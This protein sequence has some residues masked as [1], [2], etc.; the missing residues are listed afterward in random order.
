MAGLRFDLTGQ[1]LDARARAAAQLQ[2]RL[3]LFGQLL[4]SPARVLFGKF[5]L[6]PQ[7]H[8]L[9]LMRVLG[10]FNVTQLALQLANLGVES[11]GLFRVV[12]VLVA[13]ATDLILLLCV[14]RQQLATL[15]GQYARRRLLLRELLPG[16]DRDALHPAKLAFELSAALPQ[17]V[18][19]RAKSV[20]LRR[21]ALHLL[22]K[23]F[24]EQLRVHLVRLGTSAQDFKLP[25]EPLRG[26]IG[27]F[28]GG[29]C[30]VGPRSVR[31]RMRRGQTQ[32]DAVSL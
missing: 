12:A 10:H 7:P 31:E 1:L 32:H 2:E 14:D 5:E 11:D 8:R 4:V 3:G 23:L 24:E 17:F 13:E 21:R 20:L 28:V 22:L 9:G 29:R 26:G 27:V 25:P 19:L 16:L 15:L 18:L 6:R 30:R